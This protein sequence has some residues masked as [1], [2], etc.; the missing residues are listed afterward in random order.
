ME[1]PLAL[2]TQPA[3]LAQSAN[4]HHRSHLGRILLFGQP[5][6]SAAVGRGNN[7][8]QASPIQVVVE[9]RA[10]RRENRQFRRLSRYCWDIA[11][12][13]AERGGFE[14]PVQLLTVQRF[15][16]PPPSA[17]R[18]SLRNTGWNDYSGII[19]LSCLCRR[20]LHYFF[21]SSQFLS[22]G[23]SENTERETVNDY[24]A[25][26]I[27]N[28]LRMREKTVGGVAWSSPGFLSLLI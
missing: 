17:T 4:S 1:N 5:E 15:S 12:L 2:Q 24:S 6:N 18:P 16:K 26:S 10:L 23:S 11:D 27:C 7:L 19:S 28:C 14:P 25:G 21:S 8:Q 13:L 20:I 3:A 22:V 9:N